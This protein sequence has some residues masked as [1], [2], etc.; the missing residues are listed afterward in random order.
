MTIPFI[1]V[2][3]D[4]LGEELKPGQ[5]LEPCDRCGIRHV[6]R[7]GKPAGVLQS[8]RCKGRVYLVGIKYRRINLPKK[9]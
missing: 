5:R 9:E 3:N 2:G 7:D 8:I 1:A 6:V 4:E